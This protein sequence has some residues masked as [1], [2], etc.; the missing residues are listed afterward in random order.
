MASASVESLSGAQARHAEEAAGEVL[1]AV[2]LARRRGVGRQPAGFVHHHQL[3]VVVQHG[4]LGELDGLG[5]ARETVRHRPGASLAHAQ[6]V[7]AIAAANVEYA[8]AVEWCDAILDPVP[9]EIA[10]PF[11]VDVN[12]ADI[13]RP[14]APR[15]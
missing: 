8:A 5:V 6:R 14:F 4:V 13:E 15:A 2:A 12:A 3:A 11:R 10:A 7:V 1:Q 9:L